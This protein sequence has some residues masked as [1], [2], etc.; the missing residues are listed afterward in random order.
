MSNKEL[1]LIGCMFVL[2]PACREQDEIENG[3]PRPMQV[4][5]TGVVIRNTVN[6][7]DITG[8]VNLDSLEKKH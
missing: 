1:L 4:A 6:Y 7:V 2:L 5:V 8:R 3:A